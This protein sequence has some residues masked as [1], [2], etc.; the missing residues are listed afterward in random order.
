[1]ADNI[2]VE[3]CPT[4]W[5]YYYDCVRVHSQVCQISPIVCILTLSKQ[6][7]AYGVFAAHTSQ[8][9]RYMQTIQLCL[10]VASLCYCMHTQIELAAMTHSMVCK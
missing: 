5:R 8:Q 7:E 10:H 2:T 4:E 1:M 6:D 9:T 3:F